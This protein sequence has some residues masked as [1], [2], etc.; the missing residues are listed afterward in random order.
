MS[1]PGILF[2]CENI[3]DSLGDFEHN[4]MILHSKTYTPEKDYIYDV[5]NLHD[6]TLKISL[7]HEEENTS[8]PLLLAI[9]DS[10]IITDKIEFALHLKISYDDE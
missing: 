6:K 4:K 2:K 8:N 1:I 7:H 3:A 5:K 10:N 9:H